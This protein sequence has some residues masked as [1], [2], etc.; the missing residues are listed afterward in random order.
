[1]VR[2]PNC[3]EEGGVFEGLRAVPRDWRQP[4]KEFPAQGGGFPTRQDF[5]GSLCA[6]HIPPFIMTLAKSQPPH[7]TRQQ[8][9]RIHDMGLDCDYG[10][11]LFF[12]D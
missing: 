2:K 12:F 9:L 7:R 4:A 10:G 3:Y 6:S 8:R 1:L 5:T 11:L